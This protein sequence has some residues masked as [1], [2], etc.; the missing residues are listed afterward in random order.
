MQNIRNIIFDLG[1]VFIEIDYAKTQQAFTNLQVQNFHQ[2]YTQSHAND[3]F[4]ALEMGKIDA[5]T[6]YNNFRSHTNTTLADEQIK[7]SWNALLGS[8]YEDRLQWLDKIKNKYKLFLLSNTN[9]IHHKAFTKTY[10]QQT[11]KRSFDDYFIKAYYSHEIGLRKPYVEAYQYV[12]NEQGLKAEE[13]LFIDDTL[14]NIE[15]AKKAG[16][17]TIHLKPGLSLLDLDL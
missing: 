10:Q 6:F 14:P 11:G 2:F 1:G 16:L 13:T 7:E 15:G 8:F 4:E 12:L 3:L 5:A 9:A 17:Q